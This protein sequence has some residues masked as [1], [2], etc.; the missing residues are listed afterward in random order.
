[1]K[2]LLYSVEST[3][4]IESQYLL[5]VMYSERLG[6]F[7]D[8]DKAVHSFRKAAIQGH[9]ES[10]FC[11]AELY[12]SEYAK[13]I[14]F[15]DMQAEIWYLNSADRGHI[16][17]RDRIYE[18]YSKAYLKAKEMGYK[19]PAKRS[20]ADAS[21]GLRSKN[22]YEFQAI[23]FEIARE[24]F[25]ANN[26][27][28]IK[29]ISLGDLVSDYLWDSRAEGLGR[30]EAEFIFQE[31]SS[32]LIPGSAVSVDIRFLMTR[33]F[34]KKIR[35]YLTN[36]AHYADDEAYSI[37]A[38]MH[39]RLAWYASG[40]ERN[41]KSYEF[42]C[43]FGKS[44][45]SSESISELAREFDKKFYFIESRS[46]LDSE[47]KFRKLLKNGSNNELLNADE[48][49]RYRDFLRVKAL[50]E[51]SID[52]ILS[53]PFDESFIGDSDKD[54]A[55]RDFSEDFY[56]ESAAAGDLAAQ[57]GLATIYA[58]GNGATKDM[59]L[60]LHWY[61]KSADGGNAEAQFSLGDIYLAGEG[62]A[63]DFMLAMEWYEKSAMQEHSGS[64]Y[65][66]A[67]MYADGI[68]VQESI[69]KALFWYLRSAENN[70]P[71]A[72]RALGLMY[73]KGRGV[74]ESL[75]K[76]ASWYQK[77]ANLG[78]A[79]SQAT[80]ANM[81]LNGD[82]VPKSFVEAVSWISELAQQG[83][84][85][86]VVDILNKGSIQDI[87][88]KDAERAAKVFYSLGAL[89]YSAAQF[90]LGLM[91]GLG[92]GVEENKIMSYAWLSTAAEGGRDD[93]IRSLH[94]LEKTMS[95]QDVHRAKRR[96]SCFPAIAR[97]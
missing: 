71:K 27:S 46:A 41:R 79:D 4:D 3:G 44:F 12:R 2:P 16:G 1:M 54:I 56:I 76:A 53:V 65:A 57:Y 50:E 33:I 64:Q 84:S 38:D 22:I 13:K 72:F 42:D 47:A 17:A 73:S 34:T 90:N 94:E 24:W 32:F 78:C 66:I 77:A 39:C 58:T 25:D 19:F 60:A 67:E 93:A 31:V 29:D 96:L 9:A 92:F 48:V 20:Q 36:Y 18:I 62:V 69:D 89:G 55:S 51:L 68:G 87:E 30:E 40:P 81:Y 80:L 28:F 14:P 10:M 23:Y 5:G 70:N 95:L 11:L 59:S 43:S 26:K 7:G 35:E 97:W 15:A 52:E 74:P 6:E 82:G 37:S 75:V 49:E 8:I 21:E 83:Y 88:Y 85:R 45:L 91:Y 61:R 63:K 86:I